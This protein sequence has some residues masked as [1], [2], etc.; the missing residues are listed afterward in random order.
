MTIRVQILVLALGS[1]VLLTL[2]AGVGGLLVNK[3]SSPAPSPPELP[4]P[5]LLIEAH[6]LLEK[7]QL[8]EAEKN[9]RLVLKR[10]PGDPE[11]LTHLG[12][13]AAQRGDRETALRSYDEALRRDPSYIHALWDKALLLRDKGNEVAAIQAWEDFV[14]LV[15]EDSQDALI[16]KK[17]IAESRARLAAQMGVGRSNPKAP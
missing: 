12:N 3:W 9:Y 15:P 6:S 13:I 5:Q 10:E 16:V 11:A 14:R 17:W 1:A 2:G 4:V 7:G 8:V